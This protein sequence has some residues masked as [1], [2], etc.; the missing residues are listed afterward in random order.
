MS[1]SKDLANDFKSGGVYS[2]PVCRQGQISEMPLMEAV[3]CNFCR[4]IFTVDSRQQ[5]LK[6]A[7]S[8]Q[9]LSWRWNGR[10]WQNATRNDAELGWGVGLAAIALVILPT[11]LIAL[12]AYIFPPIPGSSLS[13]VPLFWMG[14]TFLSHLAF[15]VSVVVE[16]YQFPVFA[17]LQAM[18]RRLFPSS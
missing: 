12:S 14:L 2:C 13:W 7:D 8:S 5:S 4:H 17:Y 6:M 3:A 16:Y 18:R 1:N 10:R 9:P 11:S 15:V